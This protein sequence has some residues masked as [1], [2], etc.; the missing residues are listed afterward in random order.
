MLKVLAQ[1]YLVMTLCNIFIIYLQW[2]LTH[3]TRG[4]GTQTYTALFITFLALPLFICEV[5]KPT[6]IN[7]SINIFF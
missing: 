6:S 1:Y 3:N 4:I 5:I 2:R 7:T